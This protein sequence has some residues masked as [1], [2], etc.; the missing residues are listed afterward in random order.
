MRKSI[1]TPLHFHHHHHH[2]HHHHPTE[3]MVLLCVC[4]CFSPNP[5]ATFSQNRRRFFLGQSW[6]MVQGKEGLN[7]TFQPGSGWIHRNVDLGRGEKWLLRVEKSP[8]WLV[9]W[10]DWLI[11]WLVDWLIGWLVGCLVEASTQVH[12]AFLGLNALL[13]WVDWLMADWLT[14]PRPKA[15][16]KCHGLSGFDIHPF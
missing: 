5:A 2:H 8:W 6:R 13:R 10:V 4:V 14:N 15:W 7:L 16:P 3:K 11:G 9:G 1:D 12:E